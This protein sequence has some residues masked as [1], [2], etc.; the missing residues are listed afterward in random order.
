MNIVDAK[1]LSS[2][3]WNSFVE[4]N[5]PPVGAF[6]QTWSWG[7]FQKALGRAVRR[8]AVM[9][10]EK[11]IAIFTLVEFK[12]HFRNSY[13]Y[14]PRGPV[15]TKDADTK[16]IASIFEV[17]R[18]WSHQEL[19]HLIFLRIEPPILFSH[20]YKLP[21]LRFPNYYIQPRYNAMVDIK[22]SED[23]ILNSFHPSTRSNVKRAEKRGVTVTINDTINASRYGTFAKMVQDTIKR[24]DGQNA[25]P[26]DAYFHAL[27]KT[28][29]FTV[30]YGHHQGQLVSAHFVIFFAKTATYLY[31]ASNTKHLSSKVDTYLHWTAM[32]EAKKRGFEYYDLGGLDMNIWPSLTTYKRQYHGQ[33]FEY[34]GNIDIPLHSFSYFIY[35]LAR[36]IKTWLKKI[37]SKK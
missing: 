21:G 33:E 35:N 14:V 34:M 25:Y 36:N 8:Y 9:D 12:L 2:K 27:F 26:G 31:G 28:V 23:E 37:T 1:F 10:E 4:M 17:I 13:G 7:N 29:P 32:K 3:E 18:D 6:M 20:E 22:K 5:Y 24:N 15:I 19:S 11:I 30:F 16:K